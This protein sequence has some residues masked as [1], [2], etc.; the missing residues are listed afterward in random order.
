M[1]WHNFLSNIV[2]CQRGQVVGYSFI[3]EN[4]E[5]WENMTQTAVEAEANKLF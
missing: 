2:R 4:L 5:D 3:L 1:F